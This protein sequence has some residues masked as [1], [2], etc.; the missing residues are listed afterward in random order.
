MTVGA[1]LIYGLAACL[2]GSALALVLFAER[3]GVRFDDDDRGAPPPP[4]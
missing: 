1:L 4:Q 3:A 2:A